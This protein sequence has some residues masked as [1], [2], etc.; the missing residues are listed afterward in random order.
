MFGVGDR[1]DCCGVFHVQNPLFA[2][3]SRVVAKSDA[4]DRTIAQSIG[5][6]NVGR[7]IEPSNNKQ[8]GVVLV[9]AFIGKQSFQNYPPVRFSMAIL[10]AKLGTVSAAAFRIACTE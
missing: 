7:S 4:R 2:V 1:F 9:A 5:A 6:K 8:E 3:V 10:A